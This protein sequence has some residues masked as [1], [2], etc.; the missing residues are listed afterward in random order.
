[1]AI[2]INNNGTNEKVTIDGEKVKDHITLYTP[3]TSKDLI[4]PNEFFDDD[5][6]IQFSSFGISEFRHYLLSNEQIVFEFQ[7]NNGKL[8][9]ILYSPVKNCIINHIKITYPAEYSHLFFDS[10]ENAYFIFNDALYYLCQIDFINN[11][12]KT[13]SAIHSDMKK[14]GQ[15]YIVTDKYLFCYSPSGKCTYNTTT[16]KL[17]I[18]IKYMELLGNTTSAKSP[19][20]YNI[21]YETQ[22][23]KST[24]PNTIPYQ[25][26]LFGHKQSNS[27]LFV[28]IGSEYSTEGFNNNH[29]NNGVFGILNLETNSY[30]TEPNNELFYGDTKLSL[31]TFC[32]NTFHLDDGRLEFQL[33]LKDH[34]VNA[35]KNLIL[36]DYG[37]SFIKNNKQIS[38]EGVWSHA[39]NQSH[40]WN[41]NNQKIY[42]NVSNKEV[43]TL[44]D[45]E[46]LWYENQMYKYELNITKEIQM[47]SPILKAATNTNGLVFTNYFIPYAYINM[48]ENNPYWYSTQ[49]IDFIIYGTSD[50]GNYCLSFFRGLHNYNNNIYYL[51]TNLKSEADN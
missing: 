44:W 14:S 42:R 32:V 6:K 45:E 40:D 25:I 27:I 37:I 46:L 13:I 43:I 19:S 17:S 2:Y 16:N 48:R 5:L 8:N 15:K 49:I 30:M 39:W 20:T 31:D 23:Y 26:K 24:P 29:F 35:D 47:F 18:P 4:I 3:S 51:T 12:I 1:M 36:R 33:Y 38:T 50:S 7:D 9:V 41:Y 10:D 21:S 11:T 34:I 28:S 22:D